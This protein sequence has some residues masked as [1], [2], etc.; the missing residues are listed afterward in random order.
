MKALNITDKIKKPRRSH[1]A[2]SAGN[3]K[4]ATWAVEI[5]WE[6]YEYNLWTVCF[7][8]ILRDKDQWT[9]R[10]GSSLV[11]LVNSVDL[12]INTNGWG[13][14]HCGWFRMHECNAQRARQQTRNWQQ[15][16]SSLVPVF[17]QNSNGISTKVDRLDKDSAAKFENQEKEPS[18]PYRPKIAAW[19]PSSNHHWRW[20]AG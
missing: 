18:R 19:D 7:L 14:F 11:S 5:I 16:R 4:F 8:F 15:H 9:F 3:G 2:Y 13:D 17:E 1:R 10:A 12:P 6:G 20:E